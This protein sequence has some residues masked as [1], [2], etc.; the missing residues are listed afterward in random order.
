MDLHHD[1]TM[2][3]LDGVRTTVDLD[4]SL[5]ARAKRRAA[6]GRSTL[7][8][9]VN[10]A[11]RS[12]LARPPKAQEEPFE[13]ITCGTRG[14]PCPSPEEMAAELDRDDALALRV[15]GPVARADP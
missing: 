1:A 11:L 14:N 3:S 10:D 4:A 9:V 6:S 5:L 12:F 2:A 7:S 15:R 13:L 8:A